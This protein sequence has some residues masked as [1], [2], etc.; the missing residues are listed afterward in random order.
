MQ[1]MATWL[2]FSN[3]FCHRLQQSRGQQESSQWGVSTP[4]KAAERRNSNRQQ[5]TECR[6]AHFK[7]HSF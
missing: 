1:F 7:A 4:L 6:K 2:G 5:N 3:G